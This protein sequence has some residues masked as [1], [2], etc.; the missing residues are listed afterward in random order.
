LPLAAMTTKQL[1]GGG[2]GDAEAT[3]LRWG[4]H[5]AARLRR[6]RGWSRVSRAGPNG[7]GPDDEVARSSNTSSEEEEE[8]EKTREAASAKGLDMQIWALALPA[9]ASLLLDPVLGAVDTAFVGRIE[10]E[11]AANALG[12]LAIATTVF[13][14]SFKL[15]NFLA[16]VTGPLVATQIAAAQKAEGEAENETGAWGSSQDD[17]VPGSRP[18]RGAA[19]ETVAG[20]M[21]LAVVLGFSALAALELGS[22]AIIG[23][24]VALTPGCRIFYMDHTGTGWRQLNRVLTAT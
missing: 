13:N 7:G 12:G 20:A 22:D 17:D 4:N 21:T 14:F 18:G 15:F 3:P 24:V 10:G 5:H 8:D 9:V 16:V 1:G 23:R 19:A 6:R 11:G 2:G